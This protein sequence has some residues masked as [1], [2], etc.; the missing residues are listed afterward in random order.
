VC[1][2]WVNF[3]VR[4]DKG[5]GNVLVL[6]PSCGQW[7]TVRIHCKNT[8]AMRHLGNNKCAITKYRDFYKFALNLHSTVCR[9]NL[10]KMR[11]N[12]RKGKYVCG[13]YDY[14]D[15]VAPNMLLVQPI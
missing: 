5:Q 13:D 9:A 12:I 4:I 7:G 8:L 10:T 1:I 11:K 14:L 15:R 2:N 3:I 6:C